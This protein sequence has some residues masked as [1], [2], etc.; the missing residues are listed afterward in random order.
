MRQRTPTHR[1]KVCGCK[2]ILWP[3][4]KDG[5]SWWSLGTNEKCGPCCDNVAMG[6]Q[7]ETL[8]EAYDRAANGRGDYTLRDRFAM[9]ALTG[10]LANPGRLGSLSET[11]RASYE[12][13]A[14]MLA[15]REKEP[16]K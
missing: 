3:A 14:A 15:E 11:V 7:I 10:I 8:A 13:A 4:D 1:C 12:F 6:D 16:Q 9:A 2:W 5:E